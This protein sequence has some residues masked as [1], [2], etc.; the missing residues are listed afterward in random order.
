MTRL[1]LLAVGATVLL[2]AGCASGPDIRGDFDPAAD[3][4]RFRT[5]GFVEQAG[6]DSGDARSIT[7]TLLQNAAAREMEARGYVRS[8]TPDL[9]IN[10]HG[11][12]EERVDIQSRPA[13]SMGPT[14]GGWGGTE[15]TTRRYNVG[16]L[17]IDLV[18]LQQRQMV[19]QGSAQTTVTREM[20]QN[21]ERSINELV[22]QIFERFPFVAGQSA[23]VKPSS[24]K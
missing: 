18:D 6:T 15:V 17:V 10:F 19:F 16:T 24:S 11:R 3:F 23:P 7:T 2:M 20:Q 13:P 1:R 4:G 21:R 12:L 22:A 8:D 5:F 14:W 9:V